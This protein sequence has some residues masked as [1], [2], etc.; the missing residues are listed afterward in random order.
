[1]THDATNERAR[2]DAWHAQHD[3]LAAEVAALSP[4]RARQLAFALV[5]EMIAQL[6]APG[7]PLAAILVQRLAD[8]VELV[9]EMRHRLCDV[10]VPASF[11]D[12]GQRADRLHA[13]HFVQV[14]PRGT[15]PDE[16]RLPADAAEAVRRACEDDVHAALATL[17]TGARAALTRARLDPERLDDLWQEATI[18]G[19]DDLV[20]A[21][22]REPKGDVVLQALHVTGGAA[23]VDALRQPPDPPP[24][25][26]TGTTATWC[27]VHGDCACPYKHDNPDN[28]RTLDHHACPL[29]GFASDHG[30]HHA[31]ITTPEERAWCRDL[32]ARARHGAFSTKEPAT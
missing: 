5:T 32:A 24:P 10:L 28:G 3:A 29:H 6:V 9:A 30:E 25:T 26:C 2:S 4:L 12:L 21:A 17:Y 14:G 20:Q 27:P 16:L 13:W 8:V 22:A 31:S 11:A 1:M 23:A 7:A 15:W 18:A 19:L